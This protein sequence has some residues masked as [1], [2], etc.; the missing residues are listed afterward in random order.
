MIDL[1]E[2]LHWEYCKLQKTFE[3]VITLEE[4]IGS[5]TPANVKGATKSEDEKPLAKIIRKINEQYKVKFTEAY[6]MLL[7]TP[8]RTAIWNHKNPLPAC[9]KTKLSINPS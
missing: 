1:E 9:L 3:G 6:K 5:Y 2:K 8:R 7:T 4:E